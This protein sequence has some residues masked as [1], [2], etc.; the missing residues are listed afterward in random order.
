MIERIQIIGT[1]TGKLEESSYFG[2]EP[3]VP[4]SGKQ[5]PFLLSLV[6]SGDPEALGKC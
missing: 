1:I 2:A 3:I 6:T 4:T 5:Y